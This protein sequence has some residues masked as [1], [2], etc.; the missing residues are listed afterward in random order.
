M[1]K[2]GLIIQR[3]YFSRVKKRTFIIMT[4]LGP[5]LFAALM[6]APALLAQMED[7]E[8]KHVEVIDD[9]YLFAPITDTAG[10]VHRQILKDTKYINFEYFY[11]EDLDDAKEQLKGSKFYALLYIPHTVVNMQ[12]GDAQIFSYQQPNLGLKMHIVNCME[13]HLQDVKLIKKAE[14]FEITQE[15]VSEIIRVVNSSV[16]LHT[17]KLGEGGKETQSSTEVAMILGYIAGFLICM[18]VFMYGSQVMRG[19]IEEKTSRIIEVIVSS[20]RPFQLMMGKIIGVALVGLTQFLL[21][22]ILTFGLVTIV[23]AIFVDETK[24]YEMTEMIDESTGALMPE[25]SM[26]TDEAASEFSAIFSSIKAINF[27]LVIAMFI[28]FFLGGYLLYAAMFAAV[29]AAVD[30]ETDTQQFMLP[31]TVPLVLAIIVMISAIKN[32]SGSLAYWF[33]IIPFTSPIVMMVRV[34]FGVPI[35][36]VILSMTLLIIA[37][38]FMVWLAGKIYR[39]GILMYGKKVSYKEL[40]KWIRFKN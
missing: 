2:V 16:E 25:G 30:S 24:L 37:F 27:P 5:I 40:W 29:G 4:I 28:F 10:N 39:T 26:A 21:W 36:D 17:I 9:S 22:I 19:V 14:Q 8:L 20:V 3:E 23:Q 31:I 7:D 34:P 6:L 35:Q 15:E 32:P 33:S 1:S 12:K 11:G 18:F 13:K 38:V